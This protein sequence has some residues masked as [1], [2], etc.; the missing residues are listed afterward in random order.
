[1]FYA[2]TFAK[3]LQDVFSRIKHGL[4]IDSGYVQNKTQCFLGT[5]ENDVVLREDKIT[6]HRLTASP[7][8]FLKHFCK[9][10]RGGYM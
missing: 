10:F 2:K 1:M 7:A 6:Q 8:H 4:K 5:G 9:C 3:M